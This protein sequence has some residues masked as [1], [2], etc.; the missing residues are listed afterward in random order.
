[1]AQDRR[2]RQ[3]F[4]ITGYPRSRTAWMAAWLTTDRSLCFHDG[5]L[6][7]S[8]L[9]QFAARLR[10]GLEF[11]GDSDSG[12]TLWYPELRKMFP[13]A[14]WVLI[15]RDASEACAAVHKAFPEL[16]SEEQKRAAFERVGPVLEELRKDCQLHVRF[17][18][19]DDV[20]TAAGV[21]NTCLPGMVF[22]ERRWRLFNGLKVEAHHDKYLERGQVLP[23]VPERSDECLI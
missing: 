5:I 19:L 8:S 20:N 17:E 6:G 2:D 11:T 9:T 13:G 1:M 7:C 3:P 10:T 14:R 22:D 23:P 12:L 21:W 18:N 15:E 4:F 16:G